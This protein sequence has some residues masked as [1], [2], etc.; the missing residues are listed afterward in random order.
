MKVLS[1]SVLLIFLFHTNVTFAGALDDA[2][3]AIKQRNYPKAVRLL[4]PLAKKGDRVAQYHLGILIRNG[5]GTKQNP[6]LAAKWLEYSSK[7]GYDKAQYAL[8]V[9][10][11]DGNGVPQSESKAKKLLKRKK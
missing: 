2:K 10:Y 11:L 5:Q 4:H 1:L 6:R 8:G 3:Y 9:M 7:R